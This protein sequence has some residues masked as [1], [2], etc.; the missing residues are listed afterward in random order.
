ME[1]EFTYYAFISYSRKDKAFAEKLQHYLEHYRLPSVLC[2]KYPH[3]PKHVRPIFRDWTDLAIGQL[4]EKLKDALAASRYL[5]VICSE[6]SARPNA[7][8][9]NWIDEELRAFLAL[10][11]EN[12]RRVIPVICRRQGAEVTEYLPS[13]IR[14]HEISAADVADKGERRV[15]N[16]VVAAMVG[17][18][19]DVLWDRHEREQRRK[20]FLRR[21]CGGAAAALAAVASW[22]CWYYYVPHVSYYADYIERDNVPEGLFELEE[23]DV[24]QR[25]RHYRFTTCKYRLR[26]VE[27]CNS[28]GTPQEHSDYWNKERPAAMDL[29][30]EEGSG[31]LIYHVYR[32]EDRKE[33]EKRR[34]SG[35]SID[36]VQSVPHKG[37]MREVGKTISPVTLKG[38]DDKASEVGRFV[39]SRL[40]EGKCHGVVIREDFHKYGSL[41]PA[42]DSH[43]FCGRTYQLDELGRTVRVNFLVLK[44]IEPLKDEEIKEIW[45]KLEKNEQFSYDEEGKVLVSQSSDAGNHRH[46]THEGTTKQE[47]EGIMGYCLSYGNCGQVESI[48]F[49]NNSGERVNNAENWASKHFVYDERGNRILG[50][51]Y[52]ADGNLCQGEGRVAREMSKYDERGNIVEVTFCGLD[53]KLCLNDAGYAREV[54]G[55]GEDGNIVSRRF[56]GVDG[57]SCVCHDGYAEMRM[58]YNSGRVVEVSFHDE[59]G[60]LCPSRSQGCSRIV[61]QYNE[62]GNLI[63]LSYEEG[64]GPAGC[65]S[66]GYVHKRVMYNE[67]GML[68][69]VCY[70]D[71]AGNP[72][73]GE[74][75]FA[76][77]R[78]EY[79]DD[80]GM[81]VKSYYDAGGKLVMHREGY[82]RVRKWYNDVSRKEVIAYYG[83]GDQACLN[84]DGYSILAIQWDAFGNKLEMECR[85]TNGELCMHK[86]GY[87]RMTWRYEGNNRLVEEIARDSEGCIVIN[88]RFDI[89]GKLAEETRYKE[90]RP[91][92][93]MK[94]ASGNLIE[95]RWYTDGKALTTKKYHSGRMVEELLYGKD[96]KPALATRYDAEGRKLEQSTFG[97]KGC[98]RTTLCY[99]AEGRIIDEAHYDE[100]G[101]LVLLPVDGYARMALKWYDAENLSEIAYFDA[102][103]NPCL[104]SKG[105]ARKTWKHDA[106]GEITEEA[107]YGIDG[108]PCEGPD[109]YARATARYDERGNRVENAHYDVHGKLWLEPKEGYARMISRYDERSNPLETVLYGADGKLHKG[110]E[111]WA[112][113]RLSYDEHGRRVELAFFGEEDKPCAIINGRARVTYRYDAQGN[114]VEECYY[115]PDGEPCEDVKG[116]TRRTFTYD[117]DGKETSST[118]YDLHGNV[119]APR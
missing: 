18:N 71:V 112:R 106:R 47:L 3:V 82:A 118:A 91:L 97:T 105:Y 117:A 100:S 6:N 115:G 22:W 46:A 84:C 37:G 93:S 5:I 74:Q 95:E 107:F 59:N 41:E 77:M 94:Y 35:D 23:E 81:E 36:F 42:R 116:W 14:E 11:P 114:K 90:G 29:E 78:I 27:Y 75:G 62:H 113:V 31:E 21:I 56:Y 9:K 72:C 40:H 101:K 99:D 34:F 108:L 85:D 92:A 39:V 4:G 17:L 19:P 73:V 13:S 119:V 86:D 57:K 104:G 10:R 60:Q 61:R 83:P 102:D 55:Y 67:S 1:A 24:A 20:R 26:K 54:L 28:A 89:T 16:D 88:R 64:E 44:E 53:G 49:V 58:K 87:S 109:G 96:G 98:A 110:I 63:L 43:G 48:A 30:Y 68:L 32:G 103:G 38:D 12:I 65:Q 111:G 51:Y 8:G 52:G 70:Y 2:R 79:D 69:S 80:R 66:Q 15:F 50:M 76:S 33:Y 7:Y 45:E 25:H